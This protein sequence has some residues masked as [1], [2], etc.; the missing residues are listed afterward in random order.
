MTNILDF[1]TE[2]HRSRARP[3]A[4]SFCY[5]PGRSPCRP[6]GIQHRTWHQ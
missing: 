3:F 4:D 2:K 1:S 6:P 5:V